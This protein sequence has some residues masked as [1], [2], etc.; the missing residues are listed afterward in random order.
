MKKVIVFIFLILFAVNAGAEVKQEV[1]SFDGSVQNNSETIIVK[2]YQSGSIFNINLNNSGTAIDLILR[3]FSDKMYAFRNTDIE[4]KID[5]A[6]IV[7]AQ[8]IMQKP[9]FFSYY[10]LAVLNSAAFDI[11]DE[12]K[13]RILYASSIS[14]R[15]YTEIGDIVYNVPE[16]MLSEWKYVLSAPL[17]SG[18]QS[19]YKN[20]TWAM[21]GSDNYY[22]VDICDENWNI[23]DGLRGLQCSMSRSWSPKNYINRVLGVQDGVI[24]G[25]KFNWRVWS[26]SGY[27]GE[28]YEGTVTCE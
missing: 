3:I 28:G 25:F 26:P 13:N 18:Y 5:N 23:Y 10:P 14:L 4:L 11:T 12:I 9:H 20:I 8:Y 16:S 7:K 1:D 21:R 17:I 15:I 6:D 24:K 27:G 22:C 2:T 19:L